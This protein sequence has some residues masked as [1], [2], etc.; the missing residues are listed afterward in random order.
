[1]RL[2]ADAQS[3]CSLLV[4]CDVLM[5]TAGPGACVVSHFRQER[6]QMGYPVSVS[7]REDELR[8]APVA[9]LGMVSGGH[10][11]ALADRRLPVVATSI[12]PFGRL[13]HQMRCFAAWQALGF[14]VLSFNHPDEIA[15]LREAGLAEAALLPASEAETGRA[16]FGKPV[17]RVQAL[18]DRLARE[19]P[20][21]AVLLVNSDIFPAAGDAGFI[22]AWLRS[23]PALALTREETA[24]LESAIFTARAPYRGGLDAF[25]LGGPAVAAITAALADIPVAAR[26]CF[27]IPGWDYLLGALIASPRIGGQIL[28]SGILLHQSHRQTYHTIDEF[29]HF[30]PAMAALGVGGQDTAASAAESFATVISERCTA[31]SRASDLIRAMHFRPVPGRKPCS[32]AALRICARMRALLPLLR[33]S[34]NMAAMA[35]LA[36]RI[37]TEPDIDFTATLSLFVS[38]PPF[39]QQFLEVMTACLFHLDCRRPRPVTETYPAGNLHARAIQVILQGTADA[40]LLR[41][42]EFARLFATELVEHGIFNRR[43]FNYLA[44][45]C[46]NDD[47]RRVLSAIAAHVLQ[48]RAADA[49]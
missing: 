2:V 35:R 10:D 27:G 41:Q 49:A 12:N 7:G 39:R 1:M 28:D 4:G 15:R 20:D 37:I 47:E 23:A 42:V 8:L 9:R 45:C 38:G 24:S 3:L 14:E 46:M 25:L 13:E 17:P 31:D 22:S 29:A 36:D 33:W 40:P 19:Q 44:L 16:L 48:E 5:Q 32:D 30:L 11:V 18:L 21:R 34:V 26:M 6:A 43:L